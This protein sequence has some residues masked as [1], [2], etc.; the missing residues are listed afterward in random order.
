[1]S[2]ATSSALARISSLLLKPVDL[3]LHRVQLQVCRVPFAG[4][5]RD[6]LLGPG[7]VPLDLPFL[8]TPQGGLEAGLGGRIR[9]ETED[10][11]AVRHAVHPHI[12]IVP[13]DADTHRPGGTVR[14]VVIC[15]GAY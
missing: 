5:I 13:R 9:T 10:F 8:V 12:R 1:M 2:A 15:S 6:L 11:T 14:L 7:D 3:L 4:Q